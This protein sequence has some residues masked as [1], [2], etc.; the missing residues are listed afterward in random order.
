MKR[1]R[2]LVSIAAVP[3]ALGTRQVAA[4][5]APR[6]VSVT[7]TSKTAAEWPFYIAER[8]GFF[9]Q[10]GIQPDFIYTGNTAADVQQLI[11]RSVDIAEASSTLLIQ[12]VQSSAPIAAFMERDVSAPY[13]LLG[14]KGIAS[15]AQL[16]GKTII[17][18]GPADI[19]RV[20]TDKALAEAGLKPDDYTYTYAGG[21]TDRYA[22]LLSGGVDAA[23]LFPPFSFRAQSQGYPVLSDI[24]RLFPA[25]LFDSMTARKDWMP[26][27]AGVV[28]GFVKAYVQAVRWFYASGNR[29]A[30]IQLLIDETNSSPDDVTK[31]YDLFAAKR[32]FSPTGIVRSTDLVPV[33]EAMVKLGQVPGPAPAPQTYYDD[34][35]ADAANDQLRRTR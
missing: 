10:N 26:A 30:A 33:I 20:F 15:L 11:A 2:L 7:L 31:T 1:A 23:I 32:L 29:S 21:T 9:A 27:N 28:T 16:K 19:T 34:H 6:S 25:F 12:S 24:T 5:N 22:A 17:I 18:G 8:Q 13:L 35:Y 3:A 4:Q 14:R